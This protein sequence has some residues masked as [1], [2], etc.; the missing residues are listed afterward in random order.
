MTDKNHVRKEIQQMLSLIPKQ[1]YDQLSNT[2]A[3]HLVQD[4]VWKNAHTVGLTISRGTEVNTYGIIERAWKEG[5][6]VVVPKCY[7]KNR[8]MIFR[9]I[10]S[11]DHLEKVY[12]GLLEPIESQTELVNK[13][14]I[15]LL[16]IP[17]LGFTTDGNRL[18]FGGGYYDR[19]LKDYP[20]KKL[21]IAFQSQIVL[22]LPI[23]AHDQKVPI[24][25]TEKGKILDDE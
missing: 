17:G 14:E 3:N 22:T 18:G 13:D 4:P 2:I 19:F 21:S 12:Y 8:E 1:V 20:N 11:F 15:D 6:Q 7:P 24:I 23:E 10:D 25:I 9:K 5:K 16:I